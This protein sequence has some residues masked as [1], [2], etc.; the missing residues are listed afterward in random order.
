MTAGTDSF[1]V[2]F[3]DYGTLGKGS[4]LSSSLLR[5]LLC[6]EAQMTSEWILDLRHFGRLVVLLSRLLA[7]VSHNKKSYHYCLSIIVRARWSRSAQSLT[8]RSTPGKIPRQSALI[9]A[10]ERKC[11]R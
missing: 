10:S 4:V 6:P 3:W 2:L 5:H 7:V 8:V 1:L 9:T 11:L